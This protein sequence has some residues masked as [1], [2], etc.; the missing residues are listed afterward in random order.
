MRYLATILAKALDW[1][2]LQVGLR[3]CVAWSIFLS[4]FKPVCRP[5]LSRT[6]VLF[7]Y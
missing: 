4:C 1:N 6:V 2:S 7:K 3:A 5:V